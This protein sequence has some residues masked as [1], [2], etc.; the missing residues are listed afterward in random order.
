M[1]IEH[2]LQHSTSR[3]LEQH[4][5][6]SDIVMTTRIRLARNLTGIRF[7]LSFT[8]E[9]A[10]KVQEKVMSTLLSVQEQTNFSYFPMKDLSVLERQVLVEKHLISPYLAKSEQT[11]A[12]FLSADESISVMVNEED[13]LR[14]QCLAP[15]LQLTETYNRACEMDEF[16]GGKLSYAYDEQFG[17]LTSCPTNVGTGLRAS[18]MMTYLHLQCRNK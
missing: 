15:G 12:V 13:H 17:Y 8:E 7:P 11:A 14:I 3:W 5:D 2:F 4:G 10:N 9:E 16:L 18:I 1:N 6:A